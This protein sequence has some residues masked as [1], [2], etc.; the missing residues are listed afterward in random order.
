MEQL[1]PGIKLLTNKK[2]VF[3]FCNCLLIEDELCCLVDSSPD[4]A[5]RGCLEGRS[6]DLIINSHGHVDHVV[7]NPDYPGVPV[8]MHPAD[9]ALVASGQEYLRIFGFER[10]P[11]P[12]LSSRYLEAIGYRERAADATLEEGQIISTGRIEFQVL[13]LPG[14]TPGH[15]GFLFP[16]EGFIFSSDITLDPLGPWFGNLG[17]SVQAFIDSIDRVIALGPELLVPGHGRIHRKDIRA[18]LERYRD[19]LYQQAERILSSLRRNG[20]RVEELARER[21]VCRVLLQPPE[22]GFHYECIMVLNHLER[23]EALGLASR[24]GELWYA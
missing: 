24:D 21:L 6:L 5:D 17:S 4:P 10:F 12:A 19:N 7:C 3:P 2:F 9:H 8:L 11:D 14:H 20:W 18:R 1:F 13:H 15:C 16:R 22:L 23:L